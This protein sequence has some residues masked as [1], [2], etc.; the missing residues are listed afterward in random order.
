MSATIRDNIVFSYEYDEVFYNLVLDACAL[1][2]D[3]G[4]FNTP[5]T[6]LCIIDEHMRIGADAE[7]SEG[8]GEDVLRCQGLSN[9]WEGCP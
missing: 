9:A 5:I 1:R 4:G 8:K 7:E 2:P 6:K 3:L